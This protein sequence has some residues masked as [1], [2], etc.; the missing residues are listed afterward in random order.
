MKRIIVKLGQRSYP[1]I[2]GYK[3]FSRIGPALKSIR[4]GRDAIIITNN[5]LKRKLGVT[6]K[7]NLEKTGFT[8]KFEVVPD[9]EKSKSTLEVFKLVNDIG[10]YDIKRRIFIIA[11]GGGVVGDL[12]GFVAA[13]YK[14]GISYIQVP[15]TFLA[16]ID[17]AIGGKTAV[18]LSVGKNL[19]GAFYQPR[20]VFTDP[21]LLATLDRRQVRSG[22]AEAIKYGVIA[23]S[24]LFEFIEKNHKAILGLNRKVLEFVVYRCSLIKSKVVSLDE[25]E[26]RGIRT[27]LNYGHTVGHALETV[28]GYEKY[29][30]GEAVGLGMIAAA[31]ISGELNLIDKKSCQRIEHVIADAGLPTSAKKINKFRLMSVL[32]RDK[33]FVKG[34]TRFVLPVKIG[35]V[36]VR[37]DIPL[38]VID[39]AISS[40][41]KK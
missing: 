3:I 9:S 40:I 22:M 32:Y 6:L 35:K 24:K 31:R 33:K 13:I 8:V 12:A 5:F 14:R 21:A 7:R 11:L 26:Q 4:I 28:G 37:E 25:K 18:D 36:V 19:V 30:H 41:V 1:I 29:N 38:S 16:Q 15:T 39:K 23:D 10:K 34:L 2:I 20:M 17:S 27:I